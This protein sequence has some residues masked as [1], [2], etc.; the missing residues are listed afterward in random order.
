MKVST[1]LIFDFDSTFVTVEALDELAKIAL[2]NHPQKNKIT[3]K[4]SEIT[5]LGMEGKITFSDSLSKRLKLFKANKTH[6]DLLIELLKTKITPSFVRNKDFLT[7]YSSNIYIISGGFGEYIIPVV[8][9]YGIKPNHVLA[10][11]FKFNR[12]GEIKDLDGIKS[13]SANKIPKIKSLNLK[14]DIFIIGDGWTD[15]EIKK[16]GFAQKFFAFTENVKRERVIK[17]ADCVVKNFDKLLN[18]VRENL[19]SK[20]DL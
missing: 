7:E 9:E 19:I 10:N 11:Y 14:G 3:R 16:M 18:N 6:I 1:F 5:K 13:K 2:S 15:Y 20:R 4:I 8:T 17:E 12:N